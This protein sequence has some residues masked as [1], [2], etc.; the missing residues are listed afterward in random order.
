MEN[1]WSL[2]KIWNQSFETR[3]D[4]PYEPRDR[5]WASELGGSYLDRYLKMKGE[6]PS[7]PPNSRSLR[8]FEAGNLFEAI[9]GYVLKR[10]GVFISGQD[11]LEYQI[12]GLLPVSGK[13]D[14]LAGG[15]VDYDKALSTIET[16]FSWLPE[17]ISRATVGIV[18]DLKEKYPDGLKEIVLEVKSCSAFMFENYERKGTASPQHK[19]QLFHYLKT[20]GKDEGHVVY[21]C[22]DDLR[23]LEVGITN[24][25]PIEELYKKDIETMT[26]YF[27][28]GE[29]PPKENPL[30]FDADFG[31]FSANWKVAY[32]GYLTK[33]Y[34]LKDQKEFDDLYKPTSERWNRVLGRV[35]ENKEL[36][37]NNLEA[38]EEIKKSGFNVEEIVKNIQQGDQDEA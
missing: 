26:G 21:V 33:I 19:L 3:P 5:I 14:F 18:K 6:E 11:R 9:I 20:L 13:L 7:N 24:P 35:K 4:R 34:G 28:A 22:R 1:T 10:A 23:L 30:V 17:S 27:K 15:K 38:L 29:Q 2:A 25:S 16:E 31:R 37:K 8:K 12:P 36:T 32:S